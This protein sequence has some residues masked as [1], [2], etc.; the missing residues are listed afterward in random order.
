MMWRIPQEE[1]G[2]W[3]QTDITS[4]VIELLQTDELSRNFNACTC[5]IET[6]HLRL[7]L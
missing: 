6:N 5:T 3:P 7:N 4:L 2:S 1:M